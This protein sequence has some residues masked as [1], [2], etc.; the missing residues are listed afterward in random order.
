[1]RR[2]I[3]LNV[4]SIGIVLRVD[5]F[6]LFCLCFS[7]GVSIVSVLSIWCVYSVFDVVLLFQGMI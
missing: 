5:M 3:V 6:V 4:Y 2:V 7:A 1:M